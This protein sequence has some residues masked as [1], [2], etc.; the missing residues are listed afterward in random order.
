MC[1][2][3][4]III[5]III[6]SIANCQRVVWILLFSFYIFCSIGPYAGQ[7]FCQLNIYYK[8]CSLSGL[9]LSKKRRHLEPVMAAFEV[10][11]KTILSVCD[12]YVTIE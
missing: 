7:V 9:S 8:S 10:D 11:G 3:K 4:K 2:N 5:I 6:N 1:L 12:I